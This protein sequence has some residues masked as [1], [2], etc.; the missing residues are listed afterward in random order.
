[1]DF[2]FPL[3]LAQCILGL[4][5]LQKIHVILP[6]IL[7]LIFNVR[8][9]KGIFN[10]NVQGFWCKPLSVILAVQKQSV[11]LDISNWNLLQY[12][13]NIVWL[14]N[15]KYTFTAYFRVE[16]QGGK[17]SIIMLVEQLLHWE[18]ICDALKCS[19]F[20]NW[21]TDLAICANRS[22]LCCLTFTHF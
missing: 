22:G 7:G 3:S 11:I 17:G 18:H 5:Y 10:L 2:F 13:F 20:W 12:Y 6:Q 15:Q 21:A 9:Y 16:K 14:M 19:K 8:A 1:M 4:P